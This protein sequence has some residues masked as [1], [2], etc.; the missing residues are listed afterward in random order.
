MRATLLFLAALLTVA[1]QSEPSAPATTTLSAPVRV[2][3][4]EHGI[5]HIYA[6]NDTDVFLGQGY[7]MASLRG[8]ETELFRV[9]S[10]GRSSEI[11]GEDRL[12]EDYLIRSLNFQG[13]AAA[14]W[15][16]LARDY[17][18][19]ASAFRAF[20]AGINRR[21]AEYRADGWP[22]TL[23]ALIDRGYEITDWT[24]QEAFGVSMLLGFGLSGS[25][26]VK[27]LLT[28]LRLSMGTDLAE[29]LLRLAPPTTAVA[30]PSFRPNVPF[31]GAGKRAITPRP[32]PLSADLPA[33]AWKPAYDAVRKLSRLD[34]GGSNSWAVAPKHMANGLA[35][36]ESDT[37]Q[38]L[39]YPGPY[40][41]M[42]LISTRDGGSG[43]QDIIG[44][45]FPG[46]P[47][48]VFGHNN[49]VAWAPTIGY[50]DITDFYVEFADPADPTRVLRPGGISLPTIERPE[51]FRV[52]QDD[53]TFETRTVIVRD[54]P[55][56]GPI[57]PAEVLP[58]PVPVKISV[59]WAGMA[60]PGPVAAI[61]ELSQAETVDEM[62]DALRTF[63]GATIG[64][65][66]ADV[67]GNIAYSAWTLLPNRKPVGDFVPWFL[68]PGDT[69]PHWNGFVDYENVPYEINPDR[70]FVRTSNNDP[71]GNT[72]DN[73]PGNDDFYYGFAYA[74]GYRCERLDKLLRQHTAAGALTD[75]DVESIQ[76]DRYSLVA[77]R[78]IPYL[79]AAASRRPD[80]LTADLKPYF[81]TVTSWNRVAAPEEAGPTIFY[82]WLFQFVHD[83]LLDEYEIVED[84]SGNEMQILMR[85][86]WYWLEQTKDMIDEIDSGAVAFPSKSGRNLFDDRNTDG[87]IETRD[88]LIMRAFATAVSHVRRVARE[89]TTVKPLGDPDD[90]ATWKWGNLLYLR[91]EHD[92]GAISDALAGPITH[93]SAGGNFDTPN[94]GTYQ[95][96]AGGKLVDQF[97]LSNAPSN[98]FLW[99][100]D[101]DGI[102][103]RFMLASGQSELP[104]DPHF[105]DLVDS[106]ANA[107][108]RDF[109]YR[110]ADIA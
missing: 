103:A 31:T 40:V 49:K 93:Y 88:E 95:A 82:P 91:V 64:F 110:D 89:Q 28:I 54:I 50:I 58:I 8:A 16:L 83:F 18:H 11:Y 109:Y 56:H 38:G 35:L 33:A 86:A 108:Y 78:F 37:H 55:G 76:L 15:D 52:R 23:Q 12:T 22:V 71:V 98:R 21:Y 101:P 97:N 25:P 13:F 62:F 47:G 61:F 26:E 2:V 24:P 51:T 107:R 4:D 59:R 80:L 66:M 99:T 77:E 69:G 46:A 100:M 85:S 36:L 79:E 87:H 67:Q 90:P 6:S 17:P 106:Y 3:T 72:F 53:G 29:D 34:L 65:S 27:L 94:V 1:C 14:Q 63:R 19:I 48:V 92:L 9:Q 57:L 81:D 30:A 39:P 44:S 32:L 43:T 42:H 10:H 104:D 75:A 7:V 102:R 68:I 60:V 20:A 41:L 5:P 84:V 96:I 74:L 73:D 105:L 70:G 45:A